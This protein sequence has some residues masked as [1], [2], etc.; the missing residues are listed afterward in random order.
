VAAAEVPGRAVNEVAEVLAMAAGSM[1]HR[2]LV[3]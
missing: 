3:L 1:R 2:T